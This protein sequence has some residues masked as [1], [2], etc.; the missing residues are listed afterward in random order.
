MILLANITVMT[1]EVIILKFEVHE[2]FFVQ[3]VFAHIHQRLPFFFMKFFKRL[4]LPAVLCK[5][6]NAVIYYY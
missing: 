2:S 6:I 4:K 3:E 1:I 5:K